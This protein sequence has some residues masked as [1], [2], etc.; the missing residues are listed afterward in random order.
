MAFN[1]MIPRQKKQ[2]KIEFC[3]YFYHLENFGFTSSYGLLDFSYTIM[4]SA[5]KKTLVK[6]ISMSKDTRLKLAIDNSRMMCGQLRNGT[7]TIRSILSEYP[8]FIEKKFNIKNQGT[9][10]IWNVLAVQKEKK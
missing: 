9:L 1:I 3:N 6:K 2:E 7:Y 8:K 4:L 10:S 5:D